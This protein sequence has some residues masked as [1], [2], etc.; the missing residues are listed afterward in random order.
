MKTQPHKHQK[1]IKAWADGWPVQI[2]IENGA[3]IDCTAS[4]SF[5]PQCE[6]R[7]KPVIDEEPTS[8][9]VLKVTQ[10]IL[11]NAPGFE[12]KVESNIEAGYNSAV[13]LAFY[14]SRAKMA[15]FDEWLNK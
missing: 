4:P 9:K 11:E 5:Y 2:K 13:K 14:L 8:D 7:I 12:F 15:E 10:W 1:V 6:Y 3:W